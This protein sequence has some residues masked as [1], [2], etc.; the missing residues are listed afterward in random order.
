V[1]VVIGVRGRREFGEELMLVCGEPTRCRGTEGGSCLGG[2][3]RARWL[4]DSDLT[5][6]NSKSNELVWE[7]VGETVVV[8]LGTRTG[9]VVDGVDSGAVVDDD[10]SAVVGEGAGMP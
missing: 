4:V 9:K 1:V 8:E 5:T 10:E 2:A 6:S 7:D 3:T